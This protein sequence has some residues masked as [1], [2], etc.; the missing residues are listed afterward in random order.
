MELIQQL[1][2]IDCRL[3]SERDS[4][5]E[6]SEFMHKCIESLPQ[7]ERAVVYTGFYVFMNTLGRLARE[8]SDDEVK[9]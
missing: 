9:A 4:L 5:N 1:A 6:A 2:L 7:D 8:V 3:F